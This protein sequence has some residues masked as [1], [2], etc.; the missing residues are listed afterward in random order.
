MDML[1]KWQVSIQGWISASST[2]MFSPGRSVQRWVIKPTVF[3]LSLLPAVFL[4]QKAV[5]DELG[6]N[7][8][9]TLTHQ[10]GSWGLYFLLITL[11]ITPLRQYV[12]LGWLIT[13]RRMLGLFAFLYACLHLLTYL[14]LDQY[15]SLNAIVEDVLK[16]PYIT[17]GFTAWLLLLPLALT[18]TQSAVRRLGKRWVKLHKL[19]YLAVSLVLLHFLWLVKADYAEPIL[20]LCLFALLMGLRTRLINKALSGVT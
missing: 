12:G 10:T 15:F 14:W 9:E 20:Y 17:V 16:R 19:V 3:F 13:L 4:W 5:N 8:I 1:K 2:D 11:T 7:P 18:S 6:A